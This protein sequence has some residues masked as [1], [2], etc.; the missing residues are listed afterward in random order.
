MLVFD[1]ILKEGKL[2]LNYEVL[3]L[4]MRKP[5]LVKLDI[6]LLI[7]FRF[8]RFALFIYVFSKFN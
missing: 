5:L 6:S 3:A 1:I 2:R 4:R 8:S 7:K